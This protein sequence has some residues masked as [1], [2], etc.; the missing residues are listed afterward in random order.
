M[1]LETALTA[2]KQANSLFLALTDR[3]NACL[4]KAH[5]ALF[6]THK[7]LVALFKFTK[8]LLKADK[9]RH[10]RKISPARL[11]RRFQSYLIVSLHTLFIAAFCRS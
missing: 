4:A 6:V 9:I 11:F 3:G 7:A 8:A 10:L 2:D 1:A 5:T